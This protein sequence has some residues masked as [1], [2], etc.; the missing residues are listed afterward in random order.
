[1]NDITCITRPPGCVKY[2]SEVMPERYSNGP[3]IYL[4]MRLRLVSGDHRWTIFS[5]VKVHR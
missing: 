4:C 3:L 5:S 2:I 1:M